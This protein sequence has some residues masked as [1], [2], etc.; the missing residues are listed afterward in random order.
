M[1]KKSTLKKVIIIKDE[2]VRISAKKG[3]SGKYFFEDRFK[4]SFKSFSKN[5]PKLEH[6]D[7]N[8][9]EK[10]TKVKKRKLTWL[11]LLI[12]IVVVG[13]ILAFQFANE[14]VKP[15]SE[16][17]A[18]HPYYRFIFLSLALFVVI[19][20]FE[21]LK[22]L[23]LI[24]STSK[25]WRPYIAF[26]L[27]IYGKY[28]DYITPFYTGGQPFQIVELK[29][30][31]FSADIASGI[32]LAKFLFWQ[33][34]FIAF[35][36]VVF[37][38]PL[39]AIASTE[40]LVVKY[41]AIVGFSVNAI[42]LVLNFLVGINK[43]VGEKIIVGSVKIGAKL[44]IV[45]N[46]EDT[47]QRAAVF[48][49]NYQKCIKNFVSSFKIFSIQI[50]LAIGGILAQYTIAYSV[51]LTFNFPN[52]LMFSWFE[53]VSL[54]LLCEQAVSFVPLPGGAAAAEVS[55]MA[56][57][58]ALFISRGGGVVFWAMLIWRMCTY[59]LFIIQGLIVMFID[60]LIV[61]RKSKKANKIKTKLS[62]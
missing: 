57:F 12:N 48:V 4:K 46:P 25:K 31:D 54:A 58:S 5:Q 61:K 23:F 22:F 59:Y 6:E 27:A 1:I 51:Y 17:F 9:V 45:K 18:E 11:F 52:N 47:I 13:A 44:K 33:I 41:A 35:S 39:K 30:N 37:V 20:I 53:I 32:P 40:A 14:G 56:M 29:K 34:A 16:L 50:L 38:T 43:K 2:Y 8:V 10:Q 42:L 62:V 49:D 19:N 60:A 28:L 36:I 21:I 7:F 15:L 26:K 3:F 55:F 24:Y